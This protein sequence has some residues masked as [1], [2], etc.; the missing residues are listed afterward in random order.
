M[1]AFKNS[2]TDRQTDRVDSNIKK[3]AT[4]IAL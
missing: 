2:E 3:I 4:R 1:Y